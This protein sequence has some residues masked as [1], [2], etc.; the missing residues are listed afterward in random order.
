MLI[1]FFDSL[2]MFLAG[3]VLIVTAVLLIGGP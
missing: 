2:A 1:R 3:L